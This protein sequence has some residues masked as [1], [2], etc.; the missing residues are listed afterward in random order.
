[1][2]S[3]R[4]VLA[5]WSLK[6][7]V[8]F[9]Y[10]LQQ[11]EYLLNPFWGWIRSLVK[12]RNPLSGVMNRQT[13]VFTSRAK[14]LVLVGYG[15][16]LVYAAAIAVSVILSPSA[17]VAVIVTGVVLY[18]VFL[19]VAYSIIIAVATLVIAKPQEKK[20]MQRSKE[21]LAKHQAIRIVVAG[22]YGKT[23]M[24]ELLV[25]VLAKKYIIKAT[26]G[27]GNTPSAHAKFIDALGGDEDVLIFEL[28][29][30]KPGDVLQFAQTLC[31][32]YAI[33]T[34][35]APNHLDQYKTL[36]A[37]AEDI[38]SLRQFVTQG[39]VFIAGDSKTLRDY[40]RTDDLLYEE[41]GGADWHN[42]DIHITT[43]STEFRVSVDGGAAVDITSKLLGRHQVAPLGF[44]AAFAMKMGVAAQD[45]R[46]A[47]SELSPYE[48]RMRPHQLS[49]ATIIDD[50]YN[51]NAEGIMAGLALLA[52]IEAKRKVYVT[53]GLVDQGEETE[54][55]HKA[56]AAKI[57]ETKPD[58]LVLMKNSATEI[59]QKELGR[60]GYDGK[61][62]IEPAPLAFYQNLDQFVKA[63]DVV[64]MQN[65]WTDN[66]Q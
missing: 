16:Q 54:T 1:M 24:K 37:L 27:N 22:S 19:P 26:P 50:T 20:L 64:L 7:P 8:Y 6:T 29:E 2:K 58:W 25:S 46:D 39:K 44:V 57:A 5:W 4:F 41:Q 3:F 17:Y 63:G 33:I 31:P 34:G 13:L 61:I 12:T 9:V 43:T 65:D 53:P 56:I 45:V 23:T 14:L 42:T 30:G 35:L 15:A 52:E 60:R 62:T 28:G 55:V 59:I 51:G 49:G 66:Y 47:I 40:L 10:M 18:P 38:L 36:D 32:D 48:H 21:K 11:V